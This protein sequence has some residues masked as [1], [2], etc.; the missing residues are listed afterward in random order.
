MKKID[1]IALI[2]LILGGFN[3]GLVGL[4]DFNVVEAALGFPL[5]ITRIFYALIGLSALY[6]ALFW[7]AVHLRWCV[8][9]GESKELHGRVE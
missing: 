5:V 7:K 4:F 9:R 3:W 6:Y 8:H 1:V 2:F